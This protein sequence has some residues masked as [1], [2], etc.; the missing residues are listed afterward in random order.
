MANDDYGDRTEEATPHRREESRKKG[1][2]VR[3]VDLNAAGLMLA[4]AAALL[5]LGGG[6]ATSLALLLRKSLAGPRWVE[7]DSGFAL[8]QFRGLAEWAGTAVLPFLLTM[9]VAALVLNLAQVGFLFA[10]EALQPRFDRLNPIAGAQRILSLTGLVKLAVNVG[11]IVLLIALAAWFCA[12]QVPAFVELA[13]AEAATIAVVIGRKLV[14]LAFLLAAALVILGVLDYGYQ[15]W[16][17]ERDLRMTKQELRDEMKNMEGDPLIRQRRREIHRKLAQSREM[18][19]VPEADV[20]VTNPT[21]I[22]VAL[23]YDPERMEAPTIVAKGA[24]EIAL[25][26]RRIAAEHG[27][28]II[29]RK[30]LARAL[31]RAVKVGQT[32][33]VDMYEVFVEIMAYVYRITGRKPPTVG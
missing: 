1:N 3:S 12:A 16:K 7:I 23:K 26:I 25:Q 17:H 19:Q 15:R 8:V 22:S 11:K 18:Q 29:E 2:V 24:G 31:Y 33:P 4:A 13:D 20:V 27:I 14:E 9:M 21:H 28:P 10:P 5:M 30:E 32:I 6:V